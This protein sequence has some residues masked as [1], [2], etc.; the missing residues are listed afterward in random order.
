MSVVGGQSKKHITLGAHN[1]WF[2]D[3]CT[4][5]MV[6]RKRTVMA[7]LWGWCNM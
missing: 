2:P 1:P 7:T 5:D 6:V 3:T 4:G